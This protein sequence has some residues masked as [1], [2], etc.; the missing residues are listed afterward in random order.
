MSEC[1]CLAGAIGDKLGD[2]VLAHAAMDV[3]GIIV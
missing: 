3:S 1:K 2:C